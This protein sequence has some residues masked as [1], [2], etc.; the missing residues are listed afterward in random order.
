MGT[1]PYESKILESLYSVLG[2][3]EEQIKEVSGVYGYIRSSKRPPREGDS[4]RVYEIGYA[5]DFQM[6]N[7]AGSPKNF[8]LFEKQRQEVQEELMYFFSTAGAFNDYEG[9]FQIP[10]NLK[11]G[12]NASLEKQ[13]AFCKDGIAAFT[14][15]NSPESVPA[16]SIKDR[17]IHFIYLE[18][19]PAFDTEIAQSFLEATSTVI[20]QLTADFG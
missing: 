18:K 16:G 10:Q 1:F 6:L 17:G 3:S 7:L 11:D 15:I 8:E 2:M 14:H 20:R 19:A 9:I 12:L 4:E 5:W 13:E